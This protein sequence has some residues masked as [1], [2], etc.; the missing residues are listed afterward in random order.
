MNSFYQE[1]LCES[2]WWHRD[3]RHARRPA[4]I[5]KETESMQTICSGKHSLRT[6]RRALARIIQDGSRPLRQAQGPEH[7]RGTKSPSRVERPK[8]PHSLFPVKRISYLANNDVDAFFPSCA[9][10]FTRYERRRA[11]RRM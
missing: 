11:D 8:P 9:S 1:V 4:S 6:Q 5:Q 3:R 7:S 10:R 2:P